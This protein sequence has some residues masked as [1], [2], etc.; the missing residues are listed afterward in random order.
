MGADTFTIKRRQSMTIPFV[1]YGMGYYFTSSDERETSATF[2]YAKKDWDWSKKEKKG[3][4]Q[5]LFIP[6]ATI[7]IFAYFFFFF[8]TT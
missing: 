8:R 7:F 2:Q 4:K 5:L 3:R 6:V 1:L